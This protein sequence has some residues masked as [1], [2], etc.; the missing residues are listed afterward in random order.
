MPAQYYA[1]SGRFS[2]RGVVLGLLVGAAVGSVL[3]FVYAFAVLYIPLVYIRFILT[4]GFGAVAGLFAAALP[5][6]LGKMRNGRVRLVATLLVLLVAWYASWVVWVWALLRRA[7]VTGVSLLTL[8]LQPDVLWQAVLRVNEVGAWRIRSLT[9]T[10]IVLWGIW[11]IEAVIIVGLGTLLG[12]LG[13]AEPFCEHCES[14]CEKAEIARLKAADKGE[15]KRNLEAKD[16]GYL[17]Q[18]GMPATD[19]AQWT[20]L[21]LW[22]CPSCGRTNALD[23][24]AISVSRDKE[25]KNVESSQTVMKGLLL[26]QEEAGRIR[27]AGQRLAGA[28]ASA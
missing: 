6:R 25:G 18:V 28:P 13:A 19:A 15:L 7:D 26:S 11:A 23:A 8:A 14:W 17:D 5:L 21:D 1:E 27:A 3:A 9:P 4:F 12:A 2:V 20:R 10:G 24:V 16:S 22:T